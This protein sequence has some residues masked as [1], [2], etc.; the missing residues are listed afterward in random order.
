[1]SATPALQPTALE[2]LQSAYVQLP[3]EPAAV[4]QRRRAALEQFTARGFPTLRDEHWKYTSLRRLEAQEFAW[5]DRVAKVAAPVGSADRHHIV[6]VDGYYRPEHSSPPTHSGVRI[7]GLETLGQ[8]S[9]ERLVELLQTDESSD[10]FAA[11]NAALTRDGVLIEVAPQTTLDKPLQLSFFWS[12]SE[13]GL[14]A[15]PRVVV[16]AG[17]GSRFCM[18]EEF[19]ALS[20]AAHFTNMATF[21]KLEQGAQLEHHRVQNENAATVHIA[22]VRAELAAQASL[23]SHQFNLGAALARLDLEVFLQGAESSAILNGLQFATGTQHHDTHTWVH[24]CVPD[25]RSEEDYRGIADQRGRVVFNGK[26]VVREKAI[27]TDARQSSRNLLLART[28]EIDTKPE[29]EIYAD[30]VKCAHGAT[31]GQLDANAVFYLRSRGLSESQARGLLTQAF[32]DVVISRSSVPAL[33]EQ[34]AEVV[35]ARFGTRAELS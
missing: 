15:H 2:R 19:S 10:R 17:A 5:P 20:G 12:G 31:V 14:M 25:T 33:R 29:L 26:V 24:H 32:A 8:S 18:L 4:Q 13:R 6:F 3:A 30:D 16:H 7:S 21:L 23:T 1:M 11:L 28:A 9:P 34:L 35:H 22:T 27:H